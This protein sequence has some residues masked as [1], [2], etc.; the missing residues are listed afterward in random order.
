MRFMPKPTRRQLAVATALVAA[1]AVAV[2]VTS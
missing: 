2:T 1:T